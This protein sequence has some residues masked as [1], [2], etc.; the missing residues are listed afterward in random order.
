[1]KMTKLEKKN[2]NEESSLVKKIIN[3]KVCYSV[4]LFILYKQSMKLKKLTVSNLS[5]G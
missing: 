1:M 5:E 3:V 2:Q 4:D